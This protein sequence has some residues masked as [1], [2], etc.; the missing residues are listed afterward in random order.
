MTRS[1]L[2]FLVL[3]T[4]SLA[5]INCH[6]AKTAAG[7]SSGSSITVSKNFDS[8]S[9]DTLW[10]SKPNYLTGWPSHWK[11]KSSTDD[12]Y[13]WF[14]FRLNNVAG[15]DVTIQLDSLAGIYRGGP[16]LIY[17][18]GTQPVYS[19][20]QKNWQR[21]SDARYNSKAH[22]L[23]FRNTF[24]QDAVWIAYAHPF[25]FQQGSAM[26]DAI[27]GKQFLSI[28]ALGK[29]H[30]NR[31]I[32]LLTI[33]DGSVP[34][35]EKKTVFITTLQHAGE[36]CGGYVVEGL[37]KFLLSDD[38]RAATARKNTI[39]KIIPMMNP[40]GIYNGITRFNGNFED[41]NQEWDDD[42]TDTLHLPT[43]PEVA[44]VKKWLR[45]WKNDGQTIDV[46]LDIHSQGQ[47]GSMNLLHT[48]KG[49]LADLMP[50]LNKYWRVEYIP[51]EFSG[52]INNCLVKEFNIQAGTFEIPQSR[53]ENGDYL[54][55]EDYLGYGRGI[56]LGV[57]DY[58]LEK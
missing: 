21:I 26:L 38:A 50:H 9:I 17:T 52:S 3:G 44:C 28:E 47:Q 16:H 7:S 8:G 24:T 15:K 36:A 46:A 40:D 14:Y 33:T 25:S 18:K 31:N 23:T 1:G 43:E 35:A 10:E 11:H 4:I 56:V 30:Q 51:M 34:D 22:S 32:N 53:I 58:F 29:S 39:Y 48:P 13:Y 57:M 27:S 54:T 19:Y 2:A 20:D 6:Q 55:I 49:V 42:F 37:I 12:Q 45:K 41:L 5:G